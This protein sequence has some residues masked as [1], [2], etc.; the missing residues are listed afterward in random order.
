MS[1]NNDGNAEQQFREAFDRLKRGKPKVLSKGTAVTQNNV[2]R[3]AGRD[4]SALKKSRYPV[5][6]GDI[7]HWTAEFAKAAPPSPRQAA[8]K[9]RKRGVDLKAR[10]AQIAEQRDL[11]LSRLVEA[12]NKILHLTLELERAPDDKA[13][14]NVKPIT[15]TGRKGPDR[16]RT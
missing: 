2:A 15:L 8:L 11:A 14:S 3:E 9:A 10:N 13:S 4:P 7:Q 6:I 1:C 16:G 12:D 5:L